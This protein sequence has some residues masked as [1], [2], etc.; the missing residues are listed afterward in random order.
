MCYRLR[1]LLIVLALGPPALAGAWL[2]GKPVVDNYLAR[3]RQEDIWIDVGGPG[4]IMEF[5]TKCTFQDTDGE[6][7]PDGNAESP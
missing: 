6:A 4:T 7:D 3:Q 5:S 1:T 2:V